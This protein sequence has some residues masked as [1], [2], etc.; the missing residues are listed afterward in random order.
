MPTL[1]R[2][3]SIWSTGQK[4]IC[5]VL[6]GRHGERIRNPRPPS[7]TLPWHRP[8]H[9]ADDPKYGPPPDGPPSPTCLLKIDKSSTLLHLT[10]RLIS[11][12]SS[13]H[14]AQ[15]KLKTFAVACPRLGHLRAVSYL[16]ESALQRYPEV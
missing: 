2:A 16:E 13:R 6:L 12:S 15:E 8:R 14:S 7:T 1:F 5:N 10:T 9:A 11:Q 3:E 4:T